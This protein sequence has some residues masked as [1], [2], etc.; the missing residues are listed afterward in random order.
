MVVT[1]R[2]GRR[3]GTLL[4]LAA[5]VVI[6]AGMRAASGILVPMIVAAFLAVISTGPMK[7]MLS[8]GVP[9]VLAVVA[10][11][12]VIVSVMSIMGVLVGSSLTSFTSSLPAYQDRIT[13]MMAGMFSWIG[14]LGI[15]VSSPSLTESVDPS[16][17]MRMVS[18]ILAGLGGLLSNAVLIVLT[19]VFILLEQSTI[20]VKVRA[21]FGD[22]EGAFP[23][24]RQF[25]ESLNRYLAIKTVISLATG[26]LIGLWATVLGVDF[27]V[28]WGLLAFVFNYVPSIGSIIAALPA[29]L[30]AYL[31]LGMGTA[32]PLALGYFVVNMSLGNFVEPRFMGRGLG[33]STL[34]VFLSLLVWGWI[35]G[36]VGM[37]LAVPLT[38]TVKIWFECR[39][40]TRWLAILLGSASS[41]EAVCEET[42][43]PPPGTEGGT[44]PETAG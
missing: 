41:A 14:G 36:I 7:W 37:L 2:A 28:L 17:V 39:E 13:E 20:P 22:F 21:A 1:E 11:V 40:H 12:F 15:D 30:L 35:L 18:S 25:A 33:L 24:F 44:L 3:I 42:G 26:I 9:T 16:A 29:V 19:V 10:I 31:Q 4:S 5:L 38:M 43:V 27:P 32:I 23:S 34:V 6:V 8:K